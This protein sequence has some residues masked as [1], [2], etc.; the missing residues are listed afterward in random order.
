M[1]EQ[2]WLACT[3]PQKMLD[4]LRGKMSDRKLRLFECAC[5]RRIWQLLGDDRSRQAVEIAE[6][7]ADV[8]VD[9]PRQQAAFH[10]AHHAS[11][12][13]KN[14]S[15]R[16]RRVLSAEEWVAQL[17]GRKAITSALRDKAEEAEK[18]Q[19]AAEAASTLLYTPSESERDSFRHFGWRYLDTRTTIE[20]IAEA[21][22]QLNEHEAQANLLRHIFGN[23]FELYTAPDH[24]PLTVVQLTESL[25]QGQDCRLPLS[26]A[27][28]EAG[29]LE[30]AEHFRQEEWHPKGCFALDLVLEKE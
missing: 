20:S 25:Y 18:K 26:D 4:C 22:S 15:E 29:R 8:L 14:V 27:L 12:A 10:D 5:C 11:E 24:W 9:H 2:E 19:R 6:M 1:T 21:G 7:S 30:L 28:E 23:P 16:A 13:A 17:A 3:D